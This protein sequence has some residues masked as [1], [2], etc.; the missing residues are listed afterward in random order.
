MTSFVET[1]NTRM[2][3]LCFNN[4]YKLKDFVCVKFINKN[5]NVFIIKNKYFILLD[6]YKYSLKSKNSI[7][8]TYNCISK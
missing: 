4:N 1:K 7:H 2:Y 3:L 8:N 6:S 5:K